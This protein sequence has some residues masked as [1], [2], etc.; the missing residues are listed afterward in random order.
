MS[1]HQQVD[2]LGDSLSQ[3]H[4]LGGL[5]GLDVLEAHASYVALMFISDYHS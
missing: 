2:E 4:A 3:A 5:G 1:W